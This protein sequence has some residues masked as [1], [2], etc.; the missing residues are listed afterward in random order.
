MQLFERS[1]FYPL[2]GAIL[3]ILAV[4]TVVGVPVYHELDRFFL[5]NMDPDL[6][7]TYQALS[8]NAG[9]PLRFH[10]HT[11]HGYVIILTYW[12]TG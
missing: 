1:K 9:E 4:F 2:A 12:L 10:S 7:F 11:A 6:D 5:A 8:L 3:L